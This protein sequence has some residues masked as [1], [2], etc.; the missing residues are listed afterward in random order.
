MHT[1]A[2]VN[3]LCSLEFRPVLWRGDFVRDHPQKSSVTARPS[4]HGRTVGRSP[5]PA[6]VIKLLWA[7]FPKRNGLSARALSAE[8]Y[9]AAGGKV[10]MPVTQ[11]RS[12]RNIMLA[13]TYCLKRAVKRKFSRPPTRVETGKTFHGIAQL[14]GGIETPGNSPVTQSGSQMNE[15]L[16]VTALDP[17][18]APS[19]T[20]FR[21][22]VARPSDWEDERYPSSQQAA[23][24]GRNQVRRDRCPCSCG[25]VNVEILAS[26][27]H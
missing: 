13:A 22:S 9:V 15:S 21:R 17:L 24:C 3:G 19:D 27:T 20:E 4:S 25:E 16:A 5:N 7:R 26:P 6:Q 11:L 10:L 23:T 8:N 1:P 2:A 14:Q 18:F 12:L